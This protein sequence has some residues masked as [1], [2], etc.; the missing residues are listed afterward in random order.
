MSRDFNGNGIEGR[1]K[2]KGVPEK[3]RKVCWPFG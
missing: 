1:R 3:G 2:A